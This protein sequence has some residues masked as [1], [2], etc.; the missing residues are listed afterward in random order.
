MVSLSAS[1]IGK[2][3]FDY[4]FLECKPFCTFEFAPVCGTDGQTYSNQC[5]LEAKACMER[6]G[7]STAYDGA[8]RTDDEALGG[9]LPGPLGPGKHTA[10]LFKRSSPIQHHLYNTSKI[11]QFT[12]FKF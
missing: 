9:D 6:S 7:L 2:M 1:H 4:H 11:T 10:I 8:C 12:D 3:L 5:T